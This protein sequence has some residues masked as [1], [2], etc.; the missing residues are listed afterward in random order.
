MIRTTPGRVMARRGRDD[1]FAWVPAQI[2]GVWGLHE[3]VEFIETESEKFLDAE[4][5]DNGDWTITHTP[6][7]LAVPGGYTREEAEK[8]WWAL[9]V[10]YPW[11]K[12]DVTDFRAFLDAWG[13]TPE[14]KK[15]WKWLESQ[16]ARK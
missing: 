5:C 7:G 4:A 8:I 1:T 9:S 13:N 10:E 2:R 11:W 14:S 16:G 6:T 15:M 3:R 12:H